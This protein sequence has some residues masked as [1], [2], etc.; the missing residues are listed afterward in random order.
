MTAINFTAKKREI[1]KTGRF[2]VTINTVPAYNPL[3]VEYE[4]TV[5]DFG[6]PDFIRVRSCDY[7]GSEPEKI[8]KQMIEK[9]KG[10]KIIETKVYYSD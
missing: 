3:Y 9:L 2:K 6:E 1:K 4:I 7:K 8:A 5:E 10:T